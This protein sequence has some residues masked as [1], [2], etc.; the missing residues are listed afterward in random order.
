[1]NTR[2]LASTLTVA[3]NLTFVAVW[4]SEAE[5]CRQAFKNVQKNNE[6]NE[7]NERI[8]MRDLAGNLRDPT[9]LLTCHLTFH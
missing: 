3:H 8:G 7:M 9:G 1:M 2:N 5:N 6:M 4:P